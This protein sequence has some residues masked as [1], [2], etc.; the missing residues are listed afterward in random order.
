MY[1]T[2]SVFFIIYVNSVKLL[3]RAQNEKYL[4]IKQTYRVN[5]KQDNHC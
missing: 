2:G 1:K 4:K 5:V 3:S